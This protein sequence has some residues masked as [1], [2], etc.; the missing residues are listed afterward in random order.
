MAARITMTPEELRE[1]ASF[2]DSTRE[3]I[4]EKIGAVESKV[5]DLLNTWDGAAQDAFFD[6]FTNDMLPILK[7]DFPSVLEG[8]STQ[9]TSAADA[10]EQVDEE[11]ASAFRG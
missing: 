2:L 7:N 1:A 6:S 8:I 5:N 9:L 11:V 4:A 10:L 3:E